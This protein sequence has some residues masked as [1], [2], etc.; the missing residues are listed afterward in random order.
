MSLLL[1][2][3]DTQARGVPLGAFL[4]L[5]YML[6]AHLPVVRFLYYSG[7]LLAAVSLLAWPFSNRAAFGFA[8][9]AWIASLVLPYMVAVPM[10]RNLIASRRLTFV[11]KLALASGLALLALA[12]LLSFTLPAV[13]VL[14]DVPL[15]AE[16]FVPRLF[17]IA[18]A[19]TAV[20]QLCL[21]SRF[22]A[23]LLTGLP[24]LLVVLGN[25]Y[26]A[27]LGALWA[28]TGVMLVLLLASIAGWARALQLLATRATFRAPFQPGDPLVLQGDAWQQQHAR[29][30]LPQYGHSSP[31]E[32]LLHGFHASLAGRLASMVQLLL[33]SPLVMALVMTLLDERRLSAQHFWPLVLV[34]HLFM[35][36]SIPW[37]WGELAPRSRL[38]WLKLPGGRKALWRT[39]AAV[40]RRQYALM[41]S[42]TLLLALL[43]LALD[44]AL[45]LRNLHVLI[46][47]FATSLHSGYLGL[48]ARLQHWP[49]WSQALAMSLAVA[50]VGLTLVVNVQAQRSEPI[51]TLSAGL[52]LLVL[53]YHWRC[54]RAFLAVDW[55]RLKPQGPVRKG[56]AGG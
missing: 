19:Y 6:M 52:V 38:L 40:V 53:L 14:Y 2:A 23:M 34:V 42:L 8:I 29:R 18:S 39:V 32:T 49:G 27:L 12:L 10:Q 9:Y 36:A 1:A 30:W 22:G 44:S 26:S 15:P 51:W 16:Q 37:S 35:V 54:K 3:P 5:L 28:S 56:Q 31:Q 48:L 7:L 45:A 43:V 50:I 13:M 55:L 4:K 24:L 25:H 33:V 20:L 17:I 11:P 41:F 47:V 21:L 46:L